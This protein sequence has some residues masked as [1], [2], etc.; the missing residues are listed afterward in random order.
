MSQSRQAAA[1][2]K[3]SRNPH[4]AKKQKITPSEKSSTANLH[5]LIPQKGDVQKKRASQ[6]SNGSKGNT[7]LHKFNEEQ[8]IVINGQEDDVDMEDATIN[9]TNGENVDSEE[10]ISADEAD[11]VDIT[12]PLRRVPSTQDKSL[13]RSNVVDATATKKDDA[14]ADEEEDTG[15]TF[16][17]L[18]DVDNAL[19]IQDPESR[20]L[21]APN[22]S[23]RAV[24]LPSGNS[25]GT[26]L[27]QAL[28]TNDKV[29]LETCFQIND[30][31][32]VRSTIQRLESPLVSSLLSRLAE[33]IHKKP[34]RAGNL[35]V[36]VQ[37]SLVSHGGYLAGQPDVMQK[38][39]GLYRVIRE[40]ANGLQPLLA[41]K[42]KLDMLSA[43]V[44]LRRSMQRSADIGGE[45]DK[46][47][48][49]V[50]GQ[51]SDSE[52][53]GALDA[54]DVAKQQ[55][56][57]FSDDSGD[58]GIDMP[59]AHDGLDNEDED[60]EESEGLVDDEA[61]ET[62]Q[63]SGDDMSEVESEEDSDDEDISEAEEETG[64]PLRRSKAAARSALR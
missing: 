57:N 52:S 50:E 61:E 22:S 42:G 36:W 24:A 43:Q 64:A 11:E 18:I 48:I 1:T 10:E 37:W 26:V 12:R 7:R 3:P 56:E 40:R 5:A 63:D 54:T 32:S 28:K 58:D 16:G 55:V 46:A 17:E 30:L 49:Y 15:P 14:E 51:E 29:L 38:L 2:P 25:L 59:L 39:Q 47:V 53:D 6:V 60:M 45:D 31:D 9:R 34:G 35:M 20:T 4:P 41:L 8:A 44:E 23:S 62:E 21:S 27:T 19:A 33:R 13:Q